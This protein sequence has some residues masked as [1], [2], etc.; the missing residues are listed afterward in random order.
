MAVVLKLPVIFVFENNH[1]SEHTGEAYAV[2]AES[3]TARSAAFG[4][5]AVKANGID[6]FDVYQTI[7]ELIEYCK[8]GN[9]P[10]SIELDCERFYGHF[11]GDPQRY[12][13]EGELDRIREERDC[14]K[15]FRT[16]VTEAKLLDGEALDAV[17]AEVTALIERAVAE[18]KAAPKPTAQDVLE[19]VYISY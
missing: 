19:D 6:F 3:M 1:Y 10:A 18:S 2:G 13:G 9:G 7:G 8:A 16:K 4:M 15:T 12:R 17:D 11:E 5:K 14:L